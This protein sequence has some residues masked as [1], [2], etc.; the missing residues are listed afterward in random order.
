MLLSYVLL[1]GDFMSM[2]TPHPLPT[3][4]ADFTSIS[5]GAYSMVSDIWSKVI[6]TMK[7]IPILPNVR[8]LYDTTTGEWLPPL[9]SFFDVFLAALVFGSFLSVV[10]HLCTGSG[11]MTAIGSL[12]G[13]VR[14]QDQFE[15]ERKIASFNYHAGKGHGYTVGYASGAK[16]Q[17]YRH[18][19]DKSRIESLL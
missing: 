19:T 11:I 13:N 14:R 12:F 1:W 17:S 3:P 7:S 10:L 18:E 2:Y 8:G 15:R 9:V 4:N 5:S 6:N 16:N